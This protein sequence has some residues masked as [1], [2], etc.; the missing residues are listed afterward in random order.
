MD[1]RARHP[2]RRMELAVGQLVHAF[3][4]AG[5]ADVLFDDVVVRGQVLIA[6]RPVFSESVVGGGLE[7]EVAHAV[8]LPSPDVCPAAGNAQPPLPAK[9]H[10]G[11]TGRSAIRTWPLTTTSSKST[12]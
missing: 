7:V 6:E 4:Y 8:A 2:H 9:R 12:S 3:R 5:N 1:L 10:V 11:K